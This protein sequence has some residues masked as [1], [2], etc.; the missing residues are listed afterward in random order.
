MR[1][2]VVSDTHGDAEGLRIVISRLGKVMDGLIHLGDG[3]NDISG[4]RF[5]KMPQVYSVRGNVDNSWSLPPVRVVHANGRKIMLAHGHHYLET[6]S[7]RPFVLA[8]L[9]EQASAFLFGHTHV[10][11]L[12]EEDGVLLLNPGSLSRPRGIYGPSFA[13]LTVPEQPD[14]AINVKMYEL[15]GKGPITRFASINPV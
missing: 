4:L 10:P 5:L 3:A 12:G 13:I 11:Y 14:G 2:I 7:L 9:Q 1:F 6:S 15:I 8:A